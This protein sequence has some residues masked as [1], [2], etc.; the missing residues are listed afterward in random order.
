MKLYGSHV[1]L[2][3]CYG[4]KLHIGEIAFS[5]YRSL[6]GKRSLWHKENFG[7]EYVS[8]TDLCKTCERLWEIGKHIPQKHIGFSGSHCCIGGYGGR[9]T[10]D[11]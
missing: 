10:N 5:S 9:I 1:F 3:T 8:G 7:I 4:T 6:C 2:S 11:R